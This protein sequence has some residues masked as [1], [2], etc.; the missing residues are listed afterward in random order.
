MYVML[1]LALSILI[2]SL[3]GGVAGQRQ[4]LAAMYQART[5]SMQ[6][7]SMA[8]N[9]EQ[10]FIE[11][12]AFPASLDSLNASAGFEHSRALLD[13]WQG[14][15]VSPAITDSVWQFS[16]AVLISN[17]P[18]KGVDSGAYLAANACGSG[19]YDTAQ[20]WCGASTGSWFR[21]ETRERFNDQISSQ[22]ARMNRLLQKFADYYNTNQKF[23][24]QDS[25]GTALGANSISTLSALAAFGGSAGTCTGTYT[26]RGIPVDC[27]DMYDSWG[28]SIGYQFVSSKHIVL[29]CETPIYNSSGNRVV[30]AADFDNSLL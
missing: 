8:E 28:K 29:V 3:M 24:D 6:I 21:R 26:Y 10:Y 27:G 4:D 11:N 25:G 1:T 12:A 22:R 14:Y 17:D 18:S 13:N 9:V 23:P 20:S 30:V 16:R 19:G 5:K 7:V 2:G 15:A